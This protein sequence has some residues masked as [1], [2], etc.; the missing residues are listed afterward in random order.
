MKEEQLDPEGKD[1]KFPQWNG[2]EKALHY[3][4]DQFFVP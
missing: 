1:I 2:K 4:P 3:Q